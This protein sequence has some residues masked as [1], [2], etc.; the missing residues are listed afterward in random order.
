MTV[1]GAAALTCPLLQ[2]NPLNRIS[3]KKKPPKTE[4][5]PGWLTGCLDLLNFGCD[6]SSDTTQK[7][8]NKALPDGAASP[9]DTVYLIDPRFTLMFSSPLLFNY[10]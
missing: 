5:M 2:N 7:S 4:K 8:S 9:A 3:K 6:A 1:V 10:D